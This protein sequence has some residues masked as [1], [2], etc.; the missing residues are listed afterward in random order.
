MKFFVGLR[1][2]E[3]LLVI[4]IVV[5]SLAIVILYEMSDHPEVV[6]DDEKLAT[7]NA[8]TT[9]T[10]ASP[11]DGT[12]DSKPVHHTPNPGGLILSSSFSYMQDPREVHRKRPL[13]H[14]LP[15]FENIY[16]FHTTVVHQRLHAIIFHDDISFNATFVKKHTNDYI[17]FVRIEAPTFDNGEPVI[18]P[19]D[20]RYV[21]FDKWMKANA[22]QNDDGQ[23][24]VNGN[25]YGWYMITDLDMIFQRNPFPKLDDY[26][27]RQ[28]LTFFG[29]WDGGMWEHETMRL[30][31][32]LFRNC[33]GRPFILKFRDDVEWK[34]QNGNCGLW[35]GRFP[36]F[37]CVLDCMAKQYDAPPVRGK[38]EK[39][40]CDMA[41][42]DYC[43]HYGGCFPGS[44]QR[45]YDQEKVGVL[46]GNVTMGEHYELFG[47]PYGRYRQCDAKTW[48]VVHNR[49][50]WKGPLCFR[51]D[52]NGELV[53]YHQNTTGKKCRLGVDDLPLPGWE[54]HD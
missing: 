8:D 33:Y 3:K 12:Q 51:K 52:G 49:C 21:V 39:T 13:P 20:F 53:R 44:E 25:K 30:Q 47:P 50:D 24:I 23:V 11:V 40:I 36:E 37:S 34:T 17:K 1:G 22:I 16:H 41:V 5:Q 38:G 32:K 45:V 54:R 14:I 42:H 26:A 31:R 2:V 18:S 7:D 10:T 35:A 6:V 46:W 9:N 4:A 19:N 48:T 15:T 27:M 29:S 28:N 43:V